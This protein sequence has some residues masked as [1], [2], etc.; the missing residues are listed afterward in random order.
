MNR[1]D[2]QAHLVARSEGPRRI[3]SQSDLARWSADEVALA[4]ALARRPAWFV[5]GF[6]ST[7][8]AL[9]PLMKGELDPI[10]AHVPLETAD[11]LCTL[12]VGAPALD[13]LA[14]LLTPQA[15]VRRGLGRS[16]SLDALE[17]VLVALL[18]P[19]DGLTV[20]RAAWMEEPAHGASAALCVDGVSMP[21]WGASAALVS[22]YRLVSAA[23][24]AGSEALTDA[25]TRRQTEADGIGVQAERLYGSVELTAMERARLELGGGLL[26]DSYWPSGLV[27]VGRRFTRSATGWR[28][29]PE[30]RK[31]KAL[32]LRS[33]HGI[34]GLSDPDL[35]AL[36]VSSRQLD[37]LDG[38]TVIATGRL[39]PAIVD[40]TE[41]LVF[42]VDQ[43][44]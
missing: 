25:D 36:P 27:A 1:L 10:L 15:P 41:T 8:V 19:V 33:H 20:G 6:G 44:R 11:G 40:D 31:S 22:L 37:L 5:G 30:L 7:P 38:H 26:L 39:V 42:R 34:Q 28:V 17:A 3:L 35:G 21:V 16:M 32:V 12:H 9:R 13:A 18:G 23:G 29:L 4:I 14:G 24:K 43:L 2:L